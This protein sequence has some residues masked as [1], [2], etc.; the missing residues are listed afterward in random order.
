MKVIFLDFDGVLN[1]TQGKNPT[2][3]KEF[4]F[5][6]ILVKN[7]NNLLQ[8]ITDLK[9]IVTSSWRDDLEDA[10][11][12]LNKVGFSYEE[13]ILGSTE[14]LGHR[15]EEI[16]KVLELLD[17]EKYLVIDDSIDEIKEK[18]SYDYILQVDPFYGFSKLC[19]DFSSNYFLD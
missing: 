9:I 11:D 16:L 19:L 4:H 18:I 17:I 14:D 1:I 5:E 8:K 13:R 7:L 3:L 15:G 2:Y 10:I 12:Q 6:P